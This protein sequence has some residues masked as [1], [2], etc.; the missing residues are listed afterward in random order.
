[1]K[2]VE[3]IGEIVNGG[4]NRSVRMQAQSGEFVVEVCVMGASVFTAR[5]ADLEA[6]L[7]FVREQTV[8]IR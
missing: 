1:M 3:V 5:G 4:P 2:I 8:P 6:T 7:A